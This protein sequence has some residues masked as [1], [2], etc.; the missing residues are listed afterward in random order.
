MQETFTTSTWLLATIPF[1]V[2]II[3]SLANYLIS[4]RHQKQ[5]KS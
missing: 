3:L 2:L 4:R 1:S 5:G